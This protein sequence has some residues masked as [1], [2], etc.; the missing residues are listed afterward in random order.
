MSPVVLIRGVAAVGDLHG[1]LLK[2]KQALRLAGLIDSQ[3][4]WSGG[5]STLVQVGDVLDRGGQELKILYF[6][7]KLKRQ[8]V[9]V[10]G[11]VIT[12][13]GNHEIMNI[14]RNFFCVHP[15]GLDEFQNWAGWFST[16]NNM[17]QLCDGLQKPKDLYDGIPS[18][19][20]GIKQQYMNGFRARIA[21]LRP[22]GPIAT[23]FL[24]KNLTVLVVGES[25][26]VHGGILPEHVDYGLERINEDVRDWITGSRETVSSDL[27][28][29]RNSLLW[30]RKFSNETA[31]D[32]D[33]S[34]LEHA[35]STIPGARR[36]IMGH[37][38]QRGGINGACNNR[39]IRIDVGM[40]QGCINGLPEV[41]EISEDSGLRILTSNPSDHQNRH[42]LLIPEQHGPREVEVQA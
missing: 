27:V 21:A 7:E 10:G 9:K 8:A 3:D 37:T 14:D 33:C 20:P 29:T 19:F 11:N 15:S 6:L 2:S 30:L 12:M 42:D 35:L 18:T 32:C 28:R 25:V 4:R 24:S 26:F 41:L 13:N 17:K 39:A 1:D 34:L 40:S 22:Q 31:E 5:S 38:I 36:M 16:G 23:R